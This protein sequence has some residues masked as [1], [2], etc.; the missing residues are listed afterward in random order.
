MDVHQQ[1]LEQAPRLTRSD[2]FEFGCH[3]ELACFNACCADLT[4][5]LSPYDALRLERSLGL[6]EAAFLER[7]TRTR[8]DPG[9]GLPVV[10][11]EMRDDPART[12]PFVGE[13]GCSVYADRPAA[14]R[15]YPVGRALLAPDEGGGLQE[16]FF[17]LEEDPCA[18]YSQKRR[19]TVQAWLDDQGVSQVDR[20]DAPWRAVCQHPALRTRLAEGRRL[21]PGLLNDYFRAFYTPDRFRDYLGATGELARLDPA[22]RAALFNDDEAL[23]KFSAAW[24][25]ARIEGGS[26]QEELTEPTR[27]AKE[28]QEPTGG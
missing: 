4:V 6:P 13:V 2:A 18:G 19:W 27:A 26:D 1:I 10:F 22:D 17:L 5:E 14:C 12:C 7:H 15:L 24:F 28:A 8:F 23:L 25:Q 11:L 3:A 21:S 16:F 20:V 9:R